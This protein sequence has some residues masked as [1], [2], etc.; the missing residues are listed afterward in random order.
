MATPLGELILERARVLGEGDRPLSLREMTAR[1]EKYKGGPISH[2]TVGDYIN[3]TFRTPSAARLRILAEALAG[4]DIG[5][6][7]LYEKMVRAANVVAADGQTTLEVPELAQ[8]TNPEV[9]LVKDLV[10][11]LARARQADPT[12]SEND[13]DGEPSTVSPRPTS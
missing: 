2:T 1:T 3:G 12:A 8:L 10:R 5:A 6:T 4:Q 9:Q 7:E 13:D 11:A